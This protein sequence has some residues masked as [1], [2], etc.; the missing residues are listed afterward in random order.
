MTGAVRPAPAWWRTLQRI[1]RGTAR[2]QADRASRLEPGDRCVRLR[3]AFDRSRATP[4]QRLVLDVLARDG[5]MPAG[6]LASRVARELSREELRLGAWA[7]EIGVFAHLL[8]AA[9]A[10]REITAG[11]GEFW[12]FE[13]PG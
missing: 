10:A 8:F 6:T 13:V 1:R 9:D 11:V 3:P 4:V 2:R 7:A 5:P 12:D